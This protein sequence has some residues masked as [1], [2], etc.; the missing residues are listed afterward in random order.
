M[1]YPKIHCLEVM[2]SQLE[3]KQSMSKPRTLTA[4]KYFLCSGTY[5]R[6]LL[7]TPWEFRK[8]WRRR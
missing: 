4:R 1:N 8:G 7:G 3:L 5:V 6:P 2:E